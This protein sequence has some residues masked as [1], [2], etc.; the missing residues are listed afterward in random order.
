M[1]TLTLYL[2]IGMSS[3]GT[4]KVTVYHIEGITASGEHTSEIRENFIAVSRDLLK[5]YPM[6]SYVEI[7]NCPFSGKYV[8]KDKMHKKWKRKID[9]FISY[10][11][12]KYNP[13]TCNIKEFTEPKAEEAEIDST[14]TQIDT[15]TKS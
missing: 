12:K 1:L 8:V 6:N 5:A 7:S 9:I 4:V 14:P 15:L 13:C 10:N 3:I 11:G 2:W